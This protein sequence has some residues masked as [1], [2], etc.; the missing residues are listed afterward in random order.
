MLNIPV[1]FFSFYVEKQQQVTGQDS[2]LWSDRLRVGPAGAKYGWIAPVVRGSLPIRLDHGS[3]F[4]WVRFWIVNFTAERKSKLQLERRRGAWN[5]AGVLACSLTT[6]LS[7]VHGS[8]VASS[9]R[10]GK[11]TIWPNR[12]SWERWVQRKPALSGLSWPHLVG[13][14]LWC[15]N[16]RN[17][18][19]AKHIYR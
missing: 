17:W 4:C 8:A 1:F 13:S 5:R 14:S 6:V 15:C 2:V 7:A 16:L 3:E 19:R 11:S 12:W 9:R 18:R 10:S